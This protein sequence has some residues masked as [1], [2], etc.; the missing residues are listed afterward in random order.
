MAAALAEFDG[1]WD[2]LELFERRQ[3]LELLVE[4]VS[5]DAASAQVSIAFHATGLRGIGGS[6]TEVEDTAA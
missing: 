5:Y 3:A 1:V 4:W 2:T 6:N